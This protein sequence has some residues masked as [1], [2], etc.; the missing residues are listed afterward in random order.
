M[1]DQMGRNIDYLR[2]SV[3]DRCNLRCVYCMPAEGIPLLSHEDLLTFEEMERIC[4]CAAKL[5]V[6]K[7]KLTGGEPLVRLGLP[8]LARRLRALPG[9]EQVTITSNGILLGQFASELAKAGVEIVNVSLDTLDRAGFAEITRRDMLPQVLEGISA[10]LHAGMRVRVNCV[11]SRTSEPEH[12]LAVAGLARER[13]IDVRFIE[14]MPVGQGDAFQGVPTARLQKWLT[15]RYGP[16]TPDGGVGNGPAAYMEIAGFCGRLGFIS[17]VSHKFCGSCN[18]VRLTSAGFLKLCLD[19]DAGIDLREPLRRGISDD[20]LLER[21][22]GAIYR[23]P[24]GHQ[25]G[26]KK[27]SAVRSMAQIG[28]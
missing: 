12:L 5:G 6:K 27:H 22:R 17:A 23:K 18:R 21:M 11:P 25:F 26:M 28:G 24:D 19:H 2:V 15:E 14:M 3:T 7:L 16:L 8:A 9:I 10:A 4:A 20:E 1:T 13:P